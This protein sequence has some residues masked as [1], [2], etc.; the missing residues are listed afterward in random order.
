MS[1]LV[2]SRQN[3]I[4]IILFIFQSGKK[5]NQ[6]SMALGNR[7]NQMILL[8]YNVLAIP[9]QIIDEQNNFKS[10]INYRAEMNRNNATRIF[11]C[12]YSIHIPIFV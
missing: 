12:K 7:E 6:I 9:Q 3:M 1:I 2:H 8:K 11:I 5:W 4:K 10:T